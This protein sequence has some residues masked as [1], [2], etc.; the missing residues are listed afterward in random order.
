MKYQWIFFD[1]DGTLTDP[2]VGI[3]GGVMYALE[4]FGIHESSRE[5]L[6]P[7][8]G[9]VLTESFRKYYGFTQE[10]AL[11]A[12]GYYREYYGKAGKF[13]NVVYDGIADMLRELRAAGKELFVATLKGEAFAKEILEHFGLAGYF[14]EIAGQVMDGL[15]TPKSQIIMEILKKRGIDHQGR[16]VMVGDR[17]QDIIAA[18][19][20]GILEIGVL[21]GYGERAELESV[22]AKRMAADVRELWEELLH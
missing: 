4:Q 17:E 22:H 7:F 3:T 8:I 20:A 12:A 5:K 6:Y 2:A 19:E 14:T 18:R 13:E 21:Y 16:A 15:E 1:L 9:P 10:Q 11:L